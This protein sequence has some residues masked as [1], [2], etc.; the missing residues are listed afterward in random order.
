MMRGGNSLLTGSEILA[1]ARAR[2]ERD[3]DSDMN[4]DRERVFRRVVD[5]IMPA[6]DRHEPAA[7][8]EYLEAQADRHD[9]TIIWQR[10]SV[11]PKGA[12]AFADLDARRITLPII[13]PG[14]AYR[15]AVGCH[16][17]GHIC[18]GKCGGSD[19]FV[20]PY[21]KDWH[22]CLACETEAWAHALKLA[23]ASCLD[24]VHDRLRS[25]LE[26]YRESTPGPREAFRKLEELRGGLA[27]RIEKQKR[28]MGLDYYRQK[29]NQWRT[30]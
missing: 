19:H 3:V 8:T 24:L 28:V 29:L 15:F 30:A 22:R 14:H 27:L 1:R 23:P 10:P 9:T 16:E 6:V 7:L 11:F 26:I 18:A 4:A 13:E 17:Q 5:S 20:D 21:N 12:A 25:S 2:A